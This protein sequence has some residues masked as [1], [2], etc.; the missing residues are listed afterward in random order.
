[1][2][3]YVG[4]IT[5]ILYN[6]FVEKQVGVDLDRPFSKLLDYHNYT[7]PKDPHTYT[8]VYVSSHTMSYILISQGYI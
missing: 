7:A 3:V 5:I 2:Y 6:L 1:M 4:V 8:L